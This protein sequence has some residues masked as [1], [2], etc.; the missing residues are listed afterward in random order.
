[1]GRIGRGFVEPMLT[2]QFDRYYLADSSLDTALPLPC[3]QTL[4]PVFT[5]LPPVHAPHPPLAL[6]YGQE[7]KDYIFITAVELY[8]DFQTETAG[9]NV[10]YAFEKST[11]TLYCTRVYNGDCPDDPDTYFCA[12]P[13][14]SGYLTHSYMSEQL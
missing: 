9:K 4:A 3:R 14:V 12:Y 11:G 1:M 2:F 5:P 13:L 10:L 8:D 6:G 7:S